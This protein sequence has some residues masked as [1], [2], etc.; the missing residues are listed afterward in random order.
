VSRSG[1]YQRALASDHWRALRLRV[2]AAHGYACERCGMTLALLDLHHRHYRTLGEE[3][4]DDVELLCRA[5]H[6]EHHDR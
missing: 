1:D 4:L 5:C 2:L 6:E 3:S